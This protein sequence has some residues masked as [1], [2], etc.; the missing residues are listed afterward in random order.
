MPA[1]IRAHFATTPDSTSL[2]S[3]AVLSDRA[4][5]SENDVKDNSVG[6]VEVIVND[7]EKLMGIM[8]DISRRLK[9]LE[10]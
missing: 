6:V 2:E 4:I 9:K 7:S 8:E 10:T 3:L 5:A 1:S